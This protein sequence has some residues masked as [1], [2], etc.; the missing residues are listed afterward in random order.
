MTKPNEK[1]AEALKALK[2]IQGKYSGVIESRD[3][4]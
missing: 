4:T 2:K 1:L 3:L